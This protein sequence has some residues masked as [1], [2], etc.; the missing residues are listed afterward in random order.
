[1]GVLFVIMSGRGSVL[2]QNILA[3]KA[4]MVSG[5]SVITPKDH[6][7]P[8]V[9]MLPG[10]VHGGVGLEVLFDEEFILLNH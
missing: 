7:A 10:F 9:G 1:M 6:L 3:I 5:K 4:K 2:E 8:Q